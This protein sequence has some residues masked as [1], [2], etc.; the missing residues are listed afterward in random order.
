MSLDY[1]ALAAMATRL[2]TEN[3]QSVTFQ[4]KAR[5]T[6]DPAAGFSSS[7]NSTYTAKVVLLNEAKEEAADDTI[8]SE[9]QPAL[10]SSS[11]EPKISDTATIN[12]RNY[13]VVS[14]TKVQPATTVIYYDIRLAS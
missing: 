3:G 5:G 1:T 6:Y 13:R 14:V 7:S 8:Q 2:I 9:E 4:T 11:T 12:G 10:C